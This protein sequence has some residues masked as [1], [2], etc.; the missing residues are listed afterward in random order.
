MM[1]RAMAVAGETLLIAGPPK[2]I[3]EVAAFQ[4]F[5]HPST[6]KQLAEQDRALR[7]EGGARFQAVDTATGE[8]LAEYPLDSPPGF[9]GLIAAAGRVF[10]VTMD[11]RVLAFAG[12]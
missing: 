11:G 8:T 5:E 2:V 7:G 9:D 12:D 6:Q 4:A 1:V 3:D 10:L